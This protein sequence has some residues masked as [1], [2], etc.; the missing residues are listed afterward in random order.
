MKEIHCKSCIKNCHLA[1]SH[2][3]EQCQYLFFQQ[4]FIYQYLFSSQN[5][6]VNIMWYGK[7]IHSFDGSI[8]FF[9]VLMI[10]LEILFLLFFC[11]P[12]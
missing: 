11:N 5:N 12:C 8:N 9:T 6:V 7:I 10:M 4:N 2:S 1:Y 3:V